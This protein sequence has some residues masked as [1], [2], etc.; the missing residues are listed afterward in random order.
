[1]GCRTRKVYEPLTRKRFENANNRRST[2][3]NRYDN[4]S[5]NFQL[6]IE[7][8]LAGYLLFQVVVIDN[9]IKVDLEGVFNNHILQ[10][11]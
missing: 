4:N 7:V 3:K 6:G 5:N 10:S 11:T 2:R 8:I 1:M 9:N